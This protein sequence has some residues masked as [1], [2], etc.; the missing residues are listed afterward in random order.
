VKDGPPSKKLSCGCCMIGVVSLMVA[1][2]QFGSSG[3]MQI[4]VQVC[5]GA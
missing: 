1:G 5:S 2:P 3:I 4:P